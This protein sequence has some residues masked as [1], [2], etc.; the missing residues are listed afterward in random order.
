MRNLIA[1]PGQLPFCQTAGGLL[2]GGNS[3]VPIGRADEEVCDF[4]HD[5]GASRRRVRGRVSGQEGGHFVNATVIEYLGKPPVDTPVKVLAGYIDHRAHGGGRQT[6]LKWFALE[7]V[8]TPASTPTATT[9]PVPTKTRTPSPTPTG[10]PLRT[11]TPTP[12]A[13]IHAQVGR[14]HTFVPFMTQSGWQQ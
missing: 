11:S 9:T 12:T 8:N 10:V 3:L 2:A 6:A 5:H 13:T 14:H 7:P 4:S 1:I